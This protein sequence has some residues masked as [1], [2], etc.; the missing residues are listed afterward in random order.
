MTTGVPS[1]L[2]D[3]LPLSPLQQGLYFLS[4]YDDSAPDVYTV[5]I[6]VEL[7]GPLDTPRLRRAAEALLQ[8]HPNLM[9]AFRQRGNG[10]P[11]TLI[12][13]RVDLP[14]TEVDLSR[15]DP[16]EA[17]D[18]LGRLTDA[19]RLARFDLATPPLIR[20]TLVR[21]GEE[22]HRLLF[23]H[24]HLLL[25][26]WSTARVLQELFAL[27]DADGDPAALPSVPP[28]RDY[29]AWAARRDRA[30]DEAAWRHALDGLDGPTVVAPALSGTPAAEPATLDVALDPDLG[31]ALTATARRLDVTVPVVVQTLWALAVAALTGREDVVCGTTVSGR[32]AEL[33]G[34][35]HMVGLFINTLPFRVRLDT[36]PGLALAELLRRL[37]REQTALLPHHHI[38]L[39]D[40]QRL[41]GSGGPLFDTLCVFENY[42]VDGGEGRK[43]DGLRVAAVTGRDATHYPLT[44]VAAQTPD[45][46]VALR[47]RYRQDLFTAADAERIAA[48]LRRAAEELVR[49]PERPLARLDLLTA[50]EREQVL[51]AF[52]SDT[53][54]VEPATLGRLF[55]RQAAAHPGLP[56]VVDGPATLTYAELNTRANRLAH[57]LIGLGVGPEDAVG[58]AL[59]RGVHT[60]VA[61]LAIAKAGGVFAPLDPDHP[62]KRLARLVRSLD[63]RVVLT[64]AGTTA[65]EWAPGATVVHPDLV[66]EGPTH[67]PDDHDRRAPLRLDNSAYVIFTSGSTGEPK[68]VVIPHR[69]LAD[70][71]AW[72]NARFRTR[73]GDRVTQFAS[74]VFD[75][76][77]CEL[78]NS[79]FSGATLVVVPEERRAGEPLTSFLREADI[80]LAVIPP[81]V[82]AS[83]PADAGLPAGMEL[84][85]GTEALPPETVRA[86]AARHRMYNAYGPTEA[87]VNSATWPVPRDWSGG[88]VPIGP[89]DVNKR[90]YVLDRH[91]RPVAPG[92][93]GELYLAGAGLARGYLGRPG[94]TADRFVACPFAGPGTRMYR[95]GD[96]ARWNAAG[97]LEYA[98]RT[99]HQ[100]KIRGFRIEPAEVEAVLTRHPDIARAVVTGHRDDRGVKRLVAH[101]V[102][103]GERRPALADVAAWA[104]GSLPEHMVPSALVVL[105]A[106]PLTRANKIDRAALPAPEFTTATGTTP[107]RTETERVL[108]ALFTEVL[109]IPDVGVQDG[110]FALGGDSISSIQLVGAARRK[111]L[112]LRPRDV[113][114]GR[115]VE[116]LARL[117]R[118]T[119]TRSRPPSG[120]ETG[121]A[122]L[123]PVLRRLVEGGGPITGYHQSTVL[124]TPP[125]TR[126]AHLRAGLAQVLAHHA[127]LRARLTADG[128]D[129]P[130]PGTPDAATLLT[131]VDAVALPGAGLRAAL[132]EHAAPAAAALDPYA[133]TMVR[134]VWLDAGP[135]RD[136][137][138][139]VLVHHA[140][141][142]GVSWRVLTEDL[143]TAF[144]AARTGTPAAL[145]PVGTPWRTWAAGLTEA[146]ARPE[147]RAEAG[148]WHSVLTGATDR[149]A[150]PLDPGVDTHATLRTVSVRLEPGTAGT[151]L[152]P[153]TARYHTGPDAVLL[154]A[155]ALALDTLRGRRAPVTVDVEGH[156]RV[157][158][159]V[160]GADLSRT[161]G[162]FTSLHPVL[163]DL[164]GAS[165]SHDTA[166][167]RVKEQLRQAPDHGIGH[168]LLRHL[169]PGTDAGLAALPQPEIGYNYL[170]RF[171]TPDDPT[172]AGPRPWSPARTGSLG[173]GADPGLPASHTLQLDASVVDT[174]DGPVLHAAFRFPERLLDT[175]TVERL[176]RLWL[177]ALRTLGRLAEDPASGGH[178]PSDFPLVT[179][180]QHEIDALEEHGPLDDLLPLSPLQEGLFFLAGLGAEGEGPDVYTTQLVLDIEGDLD[181]ERLRAA[182]RHLLRRHPN[183]RAGF[184]TRP[185]GDPVQAVPAHDHMPFA[186]H[187]LGPD[188]EQ[189]AR[190]LLA[191]ERARPFDLARPPLMRLTVVRLGE[192]RRLLAITSHHILL[193]GWSGPLLVR[194]LLGLYHG[195]P[196]PAPRPYRDHL[197]R[198]AGRDR[199]GTARAWREA[200]AGL[201]GP[202]RLVPTA[203]GM[204][205][206]VPERVEVELPDG[207]AGRLT[208]FARERQVT[209]N[210]VL[211]TAWGLLLGLLTG[212]DDVVFG[213]TVSG[214]PADLDGAESMI[215]LFINT[216]PARVTARPDDTP[217]ALVADVAARQ[218]AL[219]DHQDESLSEILRACGHRELFDT[220]VL[221]EN[222]PVDGERLRRSEARA[223]VRVTAAEG[224]DAT[225]YPLVLVALP[226]TDRLALALDHRP[227]L[228]DR[229]ATERL[230]RLL[231]DILA[232]IVDAPDRPVHTLR[233][234]GARPYTLRGPRQEIT[235]ASLAERFL[236]RA[237]AAPSATA[238]VTGGQEWT[239]RR[240]AD[241]VGVLAERLTARGARPGT[242][243]GVALPRGADL[244]AALLAVAATGAAYLPVDPGFPADRIAFLLDDA[245][246]LLLLEPGSPLLDDGPAAGPAPFTPVRP[247]PHGT[248]YVIHTSGSTGTPKG[249]AVTHRNLA[250]LLDAMADVTGTGP[251]DRLLAVTTVSFDIAVLELFTPLVTGATVV[252]ADHDQARDPRLL[253]ALAARTGARVLQATPSLWRAVAESAPQILPG[254]TVLSGGEPL[255]PD[256]AARLAG[257][258]AR[259]VNLYG[260]TET[261]VWST[262]A[263]LPHPATDPHVGTPLRN[264]TLHV[265]DGWLRPVPQGT[266]GELYIGGAG[267][268]AGYLGRPGQTAGR[269]VAD[270]YGPPGERLYRT[271]DIAA[272]RPDGTLRVLGRADHQLKVRGHRVE[273]GEIEAALR[274]HPGVGDAVVTGRP[275]ATGAVRLVAHVTGDT[276]GLREH[277]AAR[278]PEYLVP[279]VLVPLAE[280]PLTANGKVDR[281]RL[282][283][284]GSLSAPSRAPRDAREEVLTGLFA[285]VLG[286]PSAG[287]DDDFFALGGHSLL[288]MRLA[289]RVRSALG[290][291][292]ALRDVFDH[293]TPA[294]LA[295][296]VLPRPGDRLPPARRTLEP[297]TRLPLSSAQLRL[298]FLHRLEG[299]GATYNLFFALR[300]GRGLDV[301]ALRAAVGDLVRR[302]TSL[303][304][305]FPEDEGT[306]YQHVLDTDSA[307]RALRLD[308]RPVPEDALP[309]ALRAEATAAVDLTRE[310]P[311]RVRLLRAGPDHVLTVML[312]HIAGDEWSMRPLTADLRTAYAARAEG[313]APD[314][315]ELP[316][317]YGDYA[318]WQREVLGD[319]DTP[320]SPAAIQ[321][322]HWR[323]VLAGAPGELALPYDR[324][325]PV[326][327]DPAGATVE[328]TV[329]ARAHRA[330]RALTA[331][332]GTS[333]FMAAQ[334]ALGA[335]L[336][337]HGAGTD[338]PIGTPVAGR[339]DAAL[340][341]LV[342]LFVNTLVLRTDLSGNPTFR[343]LLGRVRETD[344]AA[345][346]HADLPFERLV[347]LLSPERVLARHPLF[348]VMLAFQSLTG[349][350]PSLPGVEVSTLGADP[351]TAKFDL[352]FTLAE[353]AGADG[354]TG[355][356]TYRTALFDAATARSLADRYATL[357]GALADAPDVPF[358]RVPLLDDGELARLRA[359]S[360]GASRPL[361]DTTLPHLIAARLAE[362]PRRTA[363]VDDTGSLDRAALADRTG[364][365]ARLLRD[366]GVGPGVRVAVALPR[367]TDLVVALHAVHRAGGA[368]VPVD[369]GHPAARLAH[370]LTDSA[371]EV[372]LTDGAHAA[373][374]PV[375]AGVRL[376]LLDDPA[377]R[378]E[379]AA[380]EPAGPHPAQR[381]DDPAYVLYTSGSTGRPK[382][383]DVS[384]RAV[385]N[386]LLWMDAAHPLAADD[387][388]LQKTPAGFDV[389]VW[390]FFWPALAG[391]PL[392]VLADGAH[393]DPARVAAA[394]RRHRVTVAHFVPSM[395]AAFAAEETA[396]RTGLRT[397]F[398]S[399]EALPGPV[400]RALL[401]ALPGVRLHN[402]YGPT[403]AAVDVTAWPVGTG[404]V[405]AAVPIG[406][407]VWNTGTLVLD[408]WLRPV[409]DGV[410]GEL[411][412]TGVQLAR[413]YHARPAL[414]AE[415]FP[416]HPWGP[417]GSRMYRTGDLVRRGPGGALVFAGRADGQVKLRGLRVETGEIE[418]VLAAHPEV[419]ACA[420]VVREDRPDRRVLVGYLVPDD[421]GREQADIRRHLAEHLPEHMVPTALVALD[422]LPLTPSG[423]LDRAAL[424]APDLA[425]DATGTAPRGM[426]EAL[427]TGL[428]AELL[429]VPGAGAEDSF[430]ALGGDSILSLQ[431]VARAR[432]DGLLLTP[433]DVFAHRTPAALARVAGDGAHS[434]PP[435][436]PATGRAPLTPLM[437]WALDRGPLDG[438]F[439]Y[440]HLVTPP[441]TTRATLTAA[442]DALLARHPALRARLVTTGGEHALDLPA[443]GTPDGAGVL[444]YADLSGTAD[445]ALPKLL[446]EHAARAVAGLD[447]AHGR[448]VRA[449][450][451]DRGPG[452]EGRLLL[453]VHH[454]AVDGVSWRVLLPELA[455]AHQAARDGRAWQAPA[456]GTSF[457]QWTLALADAG[458]ARAR[459]AEAEVWRERDERARRLLG[460]RP[461]DPARDTR[462]T[463]RTLTRTLDGATTRALLTETPALVHGT[464]Q[465]VLV[466]AL[467]VALATWRHERGQGGEPADVAAVEGHGR[468]EALLPGS[469]LSTTVGWFTSWYPVVLDTGDVSPDQAL[470]DPV[471]AR[472]L[473][474][475]VK[476]HL[477]RTPDSGIGHGL[478]RQSR[479]RPHGSHDP[480]IVLNYLGRLDRAGGPA[481]P[482]ADA[483]AATPWRHAPE[484]LPA[485]H[486]AHP[487]AAPVLF[488]LEVIASTVEGEDGPVLTAR[489]AYAEGLLAEE[490]AHALAGLW[491]RTLE[492]FAQ[493]RAAPAHTPSDFPL[494]TLSPADVDALHHRLPAL[495][496]VW[497][498]TPL[499]EGLYFLSAYADEELDVYTMQLALRLD[500]AVD[501]AAL[502]AA[503]TELLSRHDNLRTAFVATPSGTPVQVVLDAAAV[504]PDWTDTDLSGLAAEEREEAL[505]ALLHED[506]TRRFDLA[507]PPLLR[508][509]L[510]RL[511]PDETVLVL[512]NHH[513]VL[514]GWSVPLLVREVLELYATRTAGAPPP[515]RRRPFRDFLAW[516]ARQEP[517]AAE[518]A[519]RRALDGVTEPTLLAPPSGADGTALSR[520]LSV[521]LDEELRTGLDTLARTADVTRNTVVQYAW[522]VLLARHTGRA[523]VVFGAT[524]SGRPPELDGAHDMAGL[525]INTLPVR[526][527][528][529]RGESVRQ[530]LAR[531]QDEQSRLSAHQ[532]LGLSHLQRIAGTGELFDTLLVFENYPVDADGLRRA[533]RSGALAVTGGESADATHYPLTL[534]VV[535]DAGRLTLE[536]RPDLFDEERAAALLRRLVH[537]LGTLAADP[538]APAHRI[539]ALTPGERHTLLGERNATAR[540]HPERTLPDLLAAAT[541]RGPARPAVVHGGTTL[542]FAGLAERSARLAHELIARGAGPEDV[543]ALMLPR[544]EEMLVAILAVL[545]A[546][547]AY[548]PLDPAHP[549]ERLAFTL[550]DAAPGVLLTTRAL[551]TR[552]PDRHAAGVLVLDDPATRARLAARPSTDP[553]D[554]ERLRPLR[555]G[556]PAYV[557]HTSG[558]TGTPKG[559][560]VSHANLVNLFHSH[561]RTLYTPLAE[562]TG[563]ERLRVGHAWSFS[564]DASWQPQL[565]LLDGHCVHILSDDL[566]HDPEALHRY[567]GDHRIDFVELA[568]SLLAQLEQA[569]LTAGGDCPVPLL[570]VGGEAVPDTQWSRLR[571][572]TTTEV[573]N[574]Y[575]P[576]EC[577]VDSLQ[578]FV[579]DSDRQV[580]GHPVDNA[581][582]HLLDAALRPVPPGVPGELYVAGAG[583]ARGY[584]GRPGLTAGRFVADPFGG[585]GGRLYRTGDL[586]RRTPGGAVEFLGRTDD[587]V[588]IRGF[589]VEP[590]EIETALLAHPGVAQAAVVAREDGG[591]RRLVGYAAGREGAAP[592]PE[593]LRGHLAATLP[594]HLVPAAVVVL[595]ALPVTAN[596]KLD[597]DR[598]PAPDFSRAAA[599]GR[600]P[601]GAAETAL[602]AAMATVLN[603]PSIAADA[604]FFALGGDSIVSMQLV[605][606]LRAEGWQVSP[607]QVFALRT[608]AA[609]AAELKRDAPARTD[610]PAGRRGRVPVTPVVEWLREL[611]GPL[612]A[613][614]QATVVQVPAAL[615]RRELDAALQALLDRHH[616]L[617]S[618]LDR[619]GGGAWSF[620]VPE[621]GTVDAAG[622]IERVDVTDVPAG[623]ELARVMGGKLLATTG[624]LDPDG[625]RMLRA[626]WFDA[627]P[628]RP[629]RLLLLLHHLV[630]DGYSWRV[631]HPDLKDA[632]EQARA[633]RTPELPPVPTSFATWARELARAAGT[634]ERE[635]ELDHWRRTLAADPGGLG[636]RPLDPATDTVRTLDHLR[637]E[638]PPE[639]TGPLLGAVAAG[640]GSTVDAVLLGA[641][642][643]A[644]ARLRSRRS[645]TGTA[646]RTVIAME[647]HGREPDAVPGTDPSRTVGWFTSVYPVLLDAEGV[648]LDA[649][650]ALPVLADR[651]ARALAAVPDKG[652]GYGMLRHL[653][654]RTGPALA[655]LG[656]PQVQFNHLGRFG[657]P[658]GASADGAAGP[659]GDWSTA[660]ETSGFSGGRDPDMPV[661]YLLDITVSAVDG[662]DGPVLGT[663]IVWPGAALPRQ[664]VEAFARDWL[665][666]LRETVR[667]RTEAGPGE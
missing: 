447:P 567:L 500:G 452:R 486:L 317:T 541:A 586:A 57:H 639:I 9:A 291:G 281:A 345:F 69:P 547:A 321:A 263:E 664:E 427:L 514:D 61:M 502:H 386:R 64:P 214:R 258:G 20:L 491:S 472:R 179:V 94:T 615:R 581:R 606:R 134:A 8:R 255:A 156:G 160:P 250:N 397:V 153:L 224:H 323:T 516:L 329:P 480:E 101:V 404:P 168:G 37:A 372:L 246:P 164:T 412:L 185:G 617:R 534:A 154:T 239:Y 441:G 26:G 492:A 100:L 625:G 192:D 287:P 200:L 462:E 132:G 305:V 253:A 368:Y 140:V 49:D 330:L 122:P 551:R 220:L 580:V 371:P 385:L 470:T 590:G 306:P 489:W 66:D 115:T 576:T 237:A 378:A 105:D 4:S 643:H 457:R 624:A 416:A 438:V 322:A 400:A 93:L 381:G 360:T 532:H 56:A 25:D 256:L 213:V 521:V 180:D 283:G 278:L 578:A 110:F 602:C 211:Q 241:R 361:P 74:P 655:A 31:A 297:G 537:L 337:G 620:L 147:R 280:L 634:P 638:L 444:L 248:A 339:T 506:R 70:L 647:G 523:D 520:R 575:G 603:L 348:Q 118:P 512:T 493:H 21:T 229:A 552:V 77:F 165:G 467:A 249:V 59:P 331:E 406:H 662:P 48:R 15:T 344:L 161:V 181:A 436:V 195:E 536:Y 553:G 346:D 507:V 646:A 439:Q 199:E 308:P 391:V 209:V 288:A 295:A 488:P 390:E 463:V 369:S 455:A 144:E 42:W 202:T 513:A 327:D 63:A 12:P 261:T 497:P 166:L 201:D 410:T 91:L 193:D 352:A 351:G 177:E 651:A 293:P 640:T 417:P 613:Y 510:V 584:L 421:A 228:L 544:T 342:G 653:N 14:W 465:D 450:W 188:Q 67:D 464:V 272:W 583:L 197:R 171:G 6:A 52:N 289:N 86:W 260:P 539:E 592:D 319:E 172:G 50:D 335:L 315:P 23:S 350:A 223:G 71:V 95:T 535:P 383:V 443:P 482:A 565:W 130:P 159:A 355:L 266:P 626:V 446:A 157:E 189:E 349:E 641:L 149:L 245:R 597:R 440:Q 341:D 394:I 238:L 574:L 469:D 598:L 210:A 252:L 158:E 43:G 99:D 376:L 277:L 460:D 425:A 631:L 175:A 343:E 196:E 284:P 127:A 235:E 442:L 484:P 379:L 347:E 637:V 364:R 303:R 273:P 150:A 511:G 459:S 33:P 276:E 476:E 274:A 518:R 525:F 218:A 589:R 496:D 219:M 403:E 318:L 611:G 466:A 388:V 18:R 569:G 304:T 610:D 145:P 555:P 644:L 11:V 365:L 509:R 609:L 268:A 661:G 453:A 375:P 487:A 167:K 407:P 207:L 187:R 353:R 599:G 475:T 660:P 522:G 468:E 426:R 294:A 282:P 654:P 471:A 227:E 114:E 262:A 30:A 648:D 405:P 103:A 366:R 88:P 190:S 257:D 176:A 124:Y 194:D 630:V 605:G 623:R 78:A 265:L 632:W 645:G 448:M 310:I 538:G 51:R 428:F 45:D 259:L 374:L 563:R 137:L 423:K 3:M 254:L 76:T 393:R 508:L 62:A 264:T 54:D 503:A 608:P 627:G 178:T 543:V 490:D 618:R 607:R 570:G 139:A 596:G 286:L 251:T 435:P 216:V 271:G 527:R 554:A 135:D 573:V 382:G 389:S 29:L 141:V 568:P 39:A 212:G 340:D 36:D 242:L 19:D 290:T 182:A 395:L 120:D 90:A 247:H 102:P 473:L 83:L 28:F 420:V 311:L 419:T 162:W 24:H 359:V 437:R 205:A 587:Q 338:L 456:P 60:E 131:R 505:R 659:D 558:S 17:A 577:T 128:L 148:H 557:I 621:P 300:L 302:H 142:D 474:A 519:W 422:R 363:L 600:A 398:A 451:C 298:W 243:V 324:P 170:G 5:Q 169:A 240:L 582:V 566:R 477:R 380:A 483:E 234:G 125:G 38:P 526:V 504:T 10:E 652:I 34:V 579:R 68:G 40:V 666:A 588:K 591:V 217:A 636:D 296:A 206:G 1:G 215:G 44:L 143:A 556:H 529:E 356:L 334:A 82:V 431:L 275:D 494:V 517:G 326:A 89:P 561:R 550:D 198:L 285:D 106:L 619:S 650:D 267:V 377:T 642:T 236:A 629:G 531:L 595:D 458:R 138:L 313:R 415:R 445:D 312:H 622:L 174:P 155:L 649:P 478:L 424:P 320:G 225:H 152:G 362:D 233:P 562:R 665:A 601:R 572:L 113:F 325:R 204:P 73:P 430:F 53:T 226:G 433:R 549:D 559:V 309:E 65:E 495:T 542:T 530:A 230:A 222:Y 208:A 401:T 499:Q 75:V 545:K 616:L 593:A 373:P 409:P 81:S 656:A 384:H 633:G 392:V 47:L 402:L 111:G 454:L 32:P 108:A 501:S 183:L 408:P 116:A 635:A 316:V 434:A 84:I 184:H 104:G 87:V 46:A 16:E 399:G 540:P 667:A 117:A 585:D 119:A 41:A 432:R 292:V 370:Q 35:E 533:E 528:E 357:L 663:G 186:E 146:A 129:I 479:G 429:G 85:V 358:W 548:L 449:L 546:G 658:A 571:A 173:G 22:H 328:F 232:G 485:P 612:G 396:G 79:L 657:S 515:P 109:G 7:R 560:V 92:V 97:E 414:T 231:S 203:A 133:G 191:E 614:S 307:L 126:A 27:Y 96:L 2:R 107:P 354:L 594:D 387:R 270:P 279:S 336:A 163:L 55:E 98:G 58:C 498:L 314:W 411:Y 367:S 413:G 151:L 269:F 301:A 604:D 80:D 112:L 418:A 13:H 121:H 461:F 299:P 244:V 481:T 333:L 221:F 524:V 332:T 123:T 564:F 628:R 136:G 72:A